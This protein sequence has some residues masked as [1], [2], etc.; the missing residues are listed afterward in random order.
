MNAKKVYL[1]GAGPGR[2]DL[3]TLRGLGILREADVVIYD[4][5]LD[6]SLLRE[7]KK[8][9]E[10]I[11]TGLLG[12]K[13][14][15]LDSAQA[16]DRISALMLEKAK[17]GK[18]VI[19]LKSGD[20]SVFSRCSQE[21]EALVKEKIE[22]EIVPGVSA[23]NAATCLSG[24]PLTDRGLASS[25]SFVTGC[26]SPQK[27]RS[28]INWSAVSGNG[29]MVL[30]MAVKNLDSI[31]KQLLKAGK[32]GNTPVAIVKDVSL[33]TQK[34]L[35]G[36]L[37]D[38]AAKAKREKI[39]PPA[40]IIIGKVVELEKR[41]NWL[42][43]NKRILF[44]G[45]SKERFFIKGTYFH[46]PLIRIEPLADYKEFDRH[47]KKIKAFDWIVFSS[48]YGVKYFF[49]RLKALKYD[50]RT[51]S[52]LKIA[53]IGNSTKS[54]LSQFGIRADLVP[55]RESSFGLI[56]EFKKIDIRKKRIFLPRS[57]ISDK[58]LSKSLRELGA[59]V[60]SSPVY[61]NVMPPDL[62]DLDLR[63]FDEIIFTSP[64]TVRNFKTRYQRIPKKVKL[65]WIGEVTEA[66]VRRQFRRHAEVKKTKK[67]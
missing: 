3:I 27:P 61:R 14:Y 34:L 28:L 54:S 19:R 17:A 45:L 36:R 50:A 44:T 37:R 55:Q 65:R 40:I 12:K 24:I 67:K 23:A 38:I 58:G 48:R 43:K 18:R 64:S 32:G 59:D 53:A 57:D 60:T 1:V 46:L 11:C 47:L 52:Q 21:L 7:A 25:C 8:D 6:K 30:Y 5:L 13:R 33:P 63:F 26:E 22:F 31:V 16:Q 41:F 51:L 10:L 62:P 20:P 35:T 49:E 39:E 56:D 9:A 2:P 15:S 42:D 66:E 4:Y 29:T